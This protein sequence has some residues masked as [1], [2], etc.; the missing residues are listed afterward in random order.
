MKYRVIAELPIL[1]A[2]KSLTTIS[3]FFLYLK[4]SVCIHGD[5]LGPVSL[6]GNDDHY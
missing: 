2:N 5:T 6:K 4:T 3:L 1:H